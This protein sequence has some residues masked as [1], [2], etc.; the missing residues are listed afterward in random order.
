MLTTWMM[1]AHEPALTKEAFYFII[2]MLL[3]PSR[4]RSRNTIWLFYDGKEYGLKVFY[5]FALQ[6]RSASDVYTI[7]TVF[8]QAWT[9]DVEQ[10]GPEKQQ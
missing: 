1:T 4:I 9:K 2:I 5:G 7:M 3:D 8:H 6:S 10:K